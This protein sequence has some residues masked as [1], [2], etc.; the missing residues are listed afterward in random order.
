MAE[1]APYRAM[2]AYTWDLVDTGPDAF[3]D[4]MAGI[5]VNTV[6]VAASYH[7]GKFIR[8]KGTSGKVYFPEDGV[9]HCRVH[10]EKYG[11]IK[12]VI[13]ELAQSDDVMGR[14][15][16][17]GGLTVQ[18]WTVLLHNSRIGALHPEA[19]TRNVYGDPLH[20]SLCPS[21]PEV[22]EYA[23]TLCADIADSYDIAGLSLETPGWLPYR[24]GYHH[25]FALI[26]DSPRC[27]FYLGL[28]FC[29][30]CKKVAHAAGIDVE[31]LEA[32]VKTRIESALSAAEETDPATDRLWL[33]NDLLLD[34]ELAAYIRMRNEVVTSLVAE[35][36]GGVRKDATVHIIPSVNQPLALS[37]MEGSDLAGID[38]A[39]D[40]LE[41]CFYSKA[42][43]VDH[44][45]VSQHI[46]HSDM[47]VVL[48]PTSAE[49]RDEG[50]FAATVAG[51]A[52]AGVDGFAFYNY[53]HMRQSGL[54]RIGRALAAI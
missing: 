45:M 46:G 44:A 5:G 34:P 40:G 24:H 29:A 47:R 3:V 31:A 8:P 1:P 22:R 15:C 33:E 6:A 32:R 50:T 37:W 19:V 26:G 2:Y 30:N 9:A 53:G 16:D 49:H 27:E 36:R 51:F 28:C 48:R 35:I 17:H 38:K 41:V 39:C 10:P 11:K 43:L 14:M 20:Y 13:G 54:D 12:P 7:A 4:E 18:A 21:A 52:D 23:V 42:A 25:E